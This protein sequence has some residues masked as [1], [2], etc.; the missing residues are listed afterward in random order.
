MFSK[1]GGIFGNFLAITKPSQTSAAMLCATRVRFTTV[2]YPILRDKLKV[3][4][5][6]TSTVKNKTNGRTHP[7]CFATVPFC[8]PSLLCHLASLQVLSMYY[9]RIDCQP[10]LSF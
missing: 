9:I 7:T 8:T 10:L 1:M 4:K 6:L 3:T 2:A 5:K